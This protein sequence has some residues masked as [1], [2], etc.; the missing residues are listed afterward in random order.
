MKELKERIKA[1]KFDRLY[2]FYGEENYLKN[3]YTNRI[4][5]ALLPGDAKFMNFDV[6]DEKTYSAVTLMQKCETVPFMADTRIILIKDSMIFAPGKKE[7]ADKTEKLIKAIP[8]NTVVIFSESKIDKRLSLFKAAAKNG[9]CVEFKTPSESDLVKWL[10]DMAKAKGKRISP[11]NCAFFLQTVNSDMEALSQEFNKLVDY[12]A[13]TIEKSDILAVTTRSVESKVFDL[14]DA[15]GN[16]KLKDALDIYNNLL[17]LKESPIGI[18]A[19][20][21][22]QFKLILACG[23]LSLMKASRQEIADKLNIKSFTVTGFIEQSRNFTQAMLKNAFKEC[24]ETD[25]NIKTGRIQD[26]LGVEMLIIKYAGQ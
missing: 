18:L 1:G 14:V 3:L 5:D 7:E 26:K 20:M 12:T 25:V 8:E 2:V 11:Q 24:L 15:V 22:R 16:K 17:F 4:T 19:M 6:L 23:E 10:S 9:S 13:D 21:A